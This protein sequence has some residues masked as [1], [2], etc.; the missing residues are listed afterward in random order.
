MP[1]LDK[2]ALDKFD[3]RL[4][5]ELDN[6][7]RQPETIL[8]KK[9]GR[10]R[11]SV[12]YRINN[13]V[14]KGIITGFNAA[15]N[16]YK[17]GYKIHK[18][19]MKLRNVPEKR[20]ELLEYL[21]NSGEV[22]WIG[23]CDGAIDLI[24][25]V[26]VK[27]DLDFSKLKNDLISKFN[28]IILSARGEILIDAR[29][30]PKMYFT[31]EVAEPT[32]FGGEVKYTQYKKIDEKILKEVIGNARVKTVELAE[33]LNCSPALVKARLE[34]LEMDG[35]II[36]YRIAVDLDKLGLE[37]YKA[38]IYF[39]KYSV[40]D[41]QRLM[42]F[43]SG[44]PST[45]YFIRNLWQIEIELAVKN[46]QEYYSTINKLRGQFPETIRNIESVLMRTDEW[47]PFPEKF[48]LIIE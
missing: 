17:L 4:L 38:I 16:P 36:Q 29:Q 44:I 11:Q 35:V 48:R 25:G 13:L 34:K 1:S 47:I 21:R 43:V 2:F 33:K 40:E 6:N 28:S 45:Q 5:S 7:C 23:E 24:F 42:R 20:S 31:G 12:K 10:S 46:Y 19:Y 37:L 8:S 3:L 14:K 27:S 41:E 39:D 26:F 18:V 15:I 22:Y 30:Y 9:V 32:F